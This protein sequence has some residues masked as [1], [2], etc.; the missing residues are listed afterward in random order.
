MSDLTEFLLACIA[1]DEA[2]ASSFLHFEVR[3]GIPGNYAIRERVLVECEAKRRVVAEHPIDTDVINPGCRV[4]D[5]T[6]EDGV[7]GDGPC[8]TLRALALPYADHPDYR[9]EWRV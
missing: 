9:E 1:E 8:A 7:W 5:S 4:C 2:G 6:P 3:D